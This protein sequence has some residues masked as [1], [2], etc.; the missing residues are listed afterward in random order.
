MNTETESRVVQQFR[1]RFVD[2]KP[3]TT[4]VTRGN[5]GAT[6]VDEPP[7]D[8]IY[9]IRKNDIRNISATYS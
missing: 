6:Q 1:I 9:A 7:S 3:E 5:T 2:E 8:L 4:R